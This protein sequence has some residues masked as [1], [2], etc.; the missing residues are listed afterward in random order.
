MAKRIVFGNGVPEVFEKPQTG[1]GT[2][3]VGCRAGSRYVEGCWGFPYLTI[4]KGLKFLGLVCLGFLFFAFLVFVFG[5]LGFLGFKD[6]LFLGVRS[7][8]LK[9]SWF[10]SFEH[11]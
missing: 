3:S 2:T 8:G 6:L 4:K 10:Q 7:L 5:D 11:P 9:L 1:Y